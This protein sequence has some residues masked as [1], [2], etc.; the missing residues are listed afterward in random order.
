MGRMLE[1]L[2]QATTEANPPETLPTASV[3]QLQV[4][5][6]DD[7]DEA[8][9]FI[10]V[11]GKGRAVEGSPD[12]LAAPALRPIAARAPALAPQS[13][14]SV[15]FH[16]GRCPAVSAPRMAG[17]IIAFHQPDHEVSQQYRA[18]LGQI[19]P[20]TADEAGRVLL[21]TAIGPAAGVTTAL[22]N[23][24]VSAS[25]TRGREVVVVDANL[26]RP[27]VAAR[28]GLTAGPGLR[29][30]LVGS[31]ALEQV[32]RGTVQ[33]HLHVLTAGA[34]PTRTTGLNSEAVHWLAAW[35]RQRFDLIFL[36]GPTCDGNAELAALMGAADRVLLVLDQADTDRPDVRAATRA[37]ARMGG[38]LGGLLVT[39]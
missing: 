12:V 29:D 21:F 18:L 17:E 34:A 22:L 5:T 2:K 28:V 9:P 8:M 39:G 1:A 32:V 15:A 37:I 4:I 25:A 13:P 3:P 6:A 11:G 24:A 26:R 33:E 27:G 10:E 16:P 30:L 35:L 38:Q 7:A 31:A 36:D 23:L 19:L 20:E 14:L